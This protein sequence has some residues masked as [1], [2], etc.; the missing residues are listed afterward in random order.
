MWTATQM[1]NNSFVYVVFTPTSYRVLPPTSKRQ[2]SYERQTIDLFLGLV[3]V[4]HS[5]NKDFNSHV[6]LGVTSLSCFDNL[7]RFPNRW[8]WIGHWKGTDPVNPVKQ[9]SE[10]RSGPTG[11]NLK[12]SLCQFLQTKPPYLAEW[13]SRM[14]ASSNFE[15]LHVKSSCATRLRNLH[16][17]TIR[18][19]QS[20]RAVRHRVWSN[21]WTWVYERVGA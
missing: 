15:Y 9:S 2:N 1:T 4:S 7:L 5:D 10:H 13:P 17:V 16:W 18:P 8:H 14:T 19:N 6:C 12:A 11:H 20:D 21:G 3:P